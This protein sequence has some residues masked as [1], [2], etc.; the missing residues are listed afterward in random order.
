MTNTAARNHLTASRTPPADTATVAPVCKSIR[1][2]ASQA[3]A[4]EVFT[5]GLDRWWPRKASI[6]TAPMKAVVFEPHLGGRWYEVGV[7]GSQAVVGKVL[8]WDPPNRFIMSW[9][10]NRHWKPDPNVGSEVEVRFTAEGPDMTLVE[11]EHRKFERMGTEAGA[12]IRKDVD[13]GWP[14]MLASF[15]ATAES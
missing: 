9:D 13:G 7:D 12:S 4:F 5:E 8:L 15:K 14:G 3:H 6:G 1:V 10:I 11:L 2:K